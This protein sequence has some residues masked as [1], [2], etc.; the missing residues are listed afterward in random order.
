LKPHEWLGSGAGEKKNEQAGT[1]PDIHVFTNM[2]GVGG[3]VAAKGFQRLTQ[4]II[5]K[6]IGEGL[7]L[8]SPR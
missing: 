3:N 6:P 5:Q 7:G 1:D 2:V 4:I 8:D